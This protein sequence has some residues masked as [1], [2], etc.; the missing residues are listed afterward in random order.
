[1]LREKTTTREDML[2]ISVDIMESVLP[3]DAQDEIPV[4]FTIVGHVGKEN[5][6]HPIDSISY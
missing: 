1:M 3:E 5:H 4:G 6:V 2:T